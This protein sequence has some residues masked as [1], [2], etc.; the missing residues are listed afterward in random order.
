MFDLLHKFGP[1]GLKALSDEQREFYRMMI[2]EEGRQPNPFFEGYSLMD[3]FLMLRFGY[4]AFSPVQIKETDD[5]VYMKSPMFFLARKLCDII[6]R[7][8]YIKLTKEGL[9]PLDVM[10]ELN[11]QDRLNL[12]PPAGTCMDHEGL[13]GKLLRLLLFE[14][15]IVRMQ[16]KRMVFRKASLKVRSDNHKLFSLLFS[17]F[18]IDLDWKQIDGL[19][20]FKRGILGCS[21]QF[22]LLKNYG[23]ISKN[24]SFYSESFLR[25][26]DFG[27][28]EQNYLWYTFEL[29]LQAWGFVVIEKK[30]HSQDYFVR[31]SALLDEIIHINPFKEFVIE[32][33]M[34]VSK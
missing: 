6:E 27:F 10:T 9:L 14:C 18:S 4:G 16:N 24:C 13:V 12:N 32:P 21:F 19:P 1:Q 20:A 29:C 15:N 8:G 34:S 11:V 31:R 3:F 33:I 26:G 17:T 25:L 2:S 5:E 7:E 28:E 22:I 30:E 23:H